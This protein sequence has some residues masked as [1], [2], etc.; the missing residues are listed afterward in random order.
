MGG[1]DERLVQRWLDRRTVRMDVAALACST[2]ELYRD[3][4]D[5]AAA[6]WHQ[7]LGETA[8]QAQ[9]IALRVWP[10]PRKPFSTDFLYSP[11]LGL[12][13]PFPV[14]H[15][16]PLGDDTAPS[17]TLWSRIKALFARGEATR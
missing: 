14:L 7:P 13:Y 15:E 2:A 3:Y 5:F 6:R 16:A 9:L 11:G 4:A 10:S 8:F 12:R 1:V 17:P